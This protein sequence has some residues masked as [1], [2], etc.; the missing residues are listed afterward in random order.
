MGH[1]G[2]PDV[3]HPYARRLR[4]TTQLLDDAEDALTAGRLRS[5]LGS[6]LR[7]ALNTPAIFASPLIGEWVFRRLVGRIIRRIRPPALAR[8]RS[9]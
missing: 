2:A 8:P 1:D 6:A 4:R 9:D 3:L 5:G 7:A